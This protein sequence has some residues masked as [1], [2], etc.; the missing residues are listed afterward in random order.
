MAVANVT[1]GKDELGHETTTM[2][3]QPAGDNFDEG[4]EGRGR[5]DI[6][7]LM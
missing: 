2:R 5:E 3:K 1:A 4:Q 6:G 7:E